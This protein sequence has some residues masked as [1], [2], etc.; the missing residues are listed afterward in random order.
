MIS[1]TGHPQI[2]VRDKDVAFI[3]W[4]AINVAQKNFNLQETERVLL[5]TCAE[6]CTEAALLSYYHHLVDQIV[7]VFD[8]K[9]FVVIRNENCEPTTFTIGQLS[10]EGDNEEVTYKHD[11]TV[12][13]ETTDHHR[14]TSFVSLSPL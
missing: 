13:L 6:Y 12:I 8:D 10:L 1:I 11:R 4:C 9:Q 5:A 7:R 14:I 2:V 3:T